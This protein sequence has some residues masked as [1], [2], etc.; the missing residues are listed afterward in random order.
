MKYLVHIC[1]LD[2]HRQA[3]LCRPYAV[4]E[5]QAVRW[6]RRRRGEKWEMRSLVE[7][8]NALEHTDFSDLI[9][10]A[11]P[12]NPA[13]VPADWSRSLIRWFS[14][15]FVCACIAGGIALIAEMSDIRTEATPP[16]A[17]SVPAHP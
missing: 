5:E 15:G 13:S 1:D 16:A 7:R 14:V 3:A 11:S 6:W 17:L 4:G 2:A 10:T 9:V 8:L 12:T